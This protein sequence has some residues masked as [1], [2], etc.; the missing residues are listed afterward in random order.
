MSAA[1]AMKREE[2][3][4]PSSVPIYEFPIRLFREYLG[5]IELSTPGGA[6]MVIDRFMHLQYRWRTDAVIKSKL[7]AIRYYLSQE[8]GE[9]FAKSVF[10]DFNIS[11]YTSGPK[12]EPPFQFLKD[13]ELDKIYDMPVDDFYDH[14]DFALID[15]LLNTGLRPREILDLQASDFDF[16]SCNL[17]VHFSAKRQGTIEHMVREIPLTEDYVANAAEYI[18][19][20]VNYADENGYKLGEDGEARKR[21]EFP[22]IVDGSK[23]GEISTLSSPRKSVNIIQKRLTQLG[24]PH[25]RAKHLRDHCSAELVEEGYS[26]AELQRFLG[27]L[28]LF[29][30][31]IGQGDVPDN[32]QEPSKLTILSWR[33]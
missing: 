28:K 3:L 4:S 5:D 11:R 7:S 29:K 33:K 24:L 12:V 6:R 9:D 26:K 21:G 19:H 16:K 30:R 10:E 13:E 27:L 25:L 8:K 32:H 15:L 14:R 31:G 22:Y 20:L 23:D 17:Y 2:H 1:A 18:C